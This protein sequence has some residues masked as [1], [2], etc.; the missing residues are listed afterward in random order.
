MVNKYLLHELKNPPYGIY[1]SIVDPITK[2][3]TEFQPGRTDIYLNKEKQQACKE[4]L[5]RFL[6]MPLTWKHLPLVGHLFGG[7]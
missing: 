5:F 4:G 1:L 2:T 7:S 6:T 3:H